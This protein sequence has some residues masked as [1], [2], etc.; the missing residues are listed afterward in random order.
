MVLFLRT[1][2]PTF[3]M[4]SPL[5][6]IHTYPPGATLPKNNA[7]SLLFSIL[8]PAISNCIQ[9]SIYLNSVLHSSPAHLPIRDS[10]P[11]AAITILA[12]IS[13]SLPI[14]FV[15]TIIPSSTLFREVAF[16]FIIILAPARAAS[17]AICLSNT[18]L[19]SIYPA[20]GILIVLLSIHTLVLFGDTN[21]TPY[22]SRAIHLGSGLIPN[23]AN[24]SLETP[25]AQRFGDPISDFLSINITSAPCNAASFA[26]SDPEGPAPTT[27]ISVSIMNIIL[28]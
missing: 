12:C 21:L 26:A 9:D 2:I 27:K 8:T 23:C 25:S 4:S 18:F 24:P 6:N 1:P 28:F 20:S 19:S 10:G 17:I 5:G 22:K 15:L 13:M 11:S 3:A 16:V 7:I 14:W